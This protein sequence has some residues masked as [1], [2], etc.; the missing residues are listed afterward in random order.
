LSGGSGIGITESG[1]TITIA[2]TDASTTN[3]L[4]NLGY[5]AS[6]RALTISN[7]TGVTLPEVTTSNTGLMT[8]AD[9][10]KLNGLRSLTPT[11]FGSGT[12]FTLDLATYVNAKKLDMNYSNTIT[13]INPVQG[14]SG[15]IEVVS[16]TFGAQITFVCSG[17]TIHIATNIHYTGDQVD[18]P[19]STRAVYSYYISTSDIYINGT[20]SYE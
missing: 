15:N 9:K 3:E 14:M 6:T 16:G 17:Y 18:L 8:S 2:A 7:G 1:N 10:T 13:I 12:T 5:T 11:V 19:A 20:E 4:Q